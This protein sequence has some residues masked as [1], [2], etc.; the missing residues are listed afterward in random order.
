M[1][2]LDWAVKPWRIYCHFLLFN[3]TQHRLQSLK[4]IVL[5]RHV[6]NCNPLALSQYISI[7]IVSSRI[8]NNKQASATV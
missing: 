7:S 5:N 2:K 1:N 8:Y 4:T 3:Q 6:I